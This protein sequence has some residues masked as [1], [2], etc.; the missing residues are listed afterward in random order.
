V[1]YKTAKLFKSV[2]PGEAMSVISDLHFSGLEVTNSKEEIKLGFEDLE[3]W[4]VNESQIIKCVFWND[5]KWSEEG[6]RYEPLERACFC[7]HATPFTSILVSKFS[8]PTC[9]VYNYQQSCNILT[10]RSTVKH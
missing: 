4:S 2:G 10:Y 9:I 5:N 7:N 6:C 8:L 3:N 1:V